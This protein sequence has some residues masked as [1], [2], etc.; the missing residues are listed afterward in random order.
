[1]ARSA[2]L[3]R[4][5]LAPGTGARI[6]GVN[7]GNWLVLERWMEGTEE[8]TGKGAGSDVPRPFAGTDADDEYGLRKELTPDELLRRLESH[9]ASYVTRDTFAWLAEVG[10]NLV[11]IPVPYHVF[12]DERHESCVAYLDAALDWAAETGIGA[13]VDLHT[14]PGGQ[15][16]FDN[17]GVSGLC[18]WHLESPQVARTLEVLERLARR[19]A[20]HEALVAFEPMNEPA[21]ARIFAGSMERYG[22]A[23]PGRVERS[24]PIPHH[25]LAQ[26]Y[27]LV[28]ER[29]RP[30]LGREVALVFHDQFQLGAWSRFMPA[31][32]FPNV[33]LDA[34]LY[35]GTITRGLHI[36]SLRGHLAVIGALAARIALAQ[37][38]HPVLVGEWSLAHN[39]GGGN[40]RLTP[41]RRDEVC[42]TLASAQLAAFDRGVGS[43]FW[44]LRNERRATWSLER[45][46][47]RGWLSLQP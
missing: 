23:H 39:V 28:Y 27:R 42:R 29:I 35:V 15:N 4:P 26:Y 1:M 24:A 34:H 8:G 47:A 5:L 13:L 17:S 45:A 2:A 33:W 36:R 19:Y 41:E 31:D 32:R 21:S 11:R 6:H 44:S 37:R 30:I 9:R 10:C 46:I 38:H 40:A 3:T 22:A 20:G 12:G 7:L 16:G 14:V 18:T 25:V 43:C